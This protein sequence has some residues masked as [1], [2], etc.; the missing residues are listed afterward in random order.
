M[1]TH[2]MGYGWLP[3][4]D[5]CRNDSLRHLGF[6][7]VLVSGLF[8]CGTEPPKP[9]SGEAGVGGD[10]SCLVEGKRHPDGTTGIPAADGC[11]TC[12]CNHGQLGC[13]TIGCVDKP[14]C[15][16]AARRSR[17]RH[18]PSA[19]ATASASELTPQAFHSRALR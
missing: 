16:V 10:G 7:A 6:A 2:I 14:Q 19:T 9:L 13:T 5:S 3:C 17:S 4:G 15:V 11:N 18:A 1:G 12:F 8:A